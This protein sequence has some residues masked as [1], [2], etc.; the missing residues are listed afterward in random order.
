MSDFV[1]WLHDDITWCCYDE[2]PH[3]DCER[4]TFNMY[5]QEGLH[6]YSMFKGTDMCPHK[7]DFIN[8]ED[9]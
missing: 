5:K 3:T 9:N 2:C 4:N 7:E 6:S 8:N 1:N